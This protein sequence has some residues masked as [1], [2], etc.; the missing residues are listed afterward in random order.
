MRFQVPDEV[1]LLRKPLVTI[2]AEIRFLTAVYQHVLI[3]LALGRESFTALVTP[4]ILLAGVYF[5]VSVEVARTGKPA[6]KRNK[7]D[8]FKR[9]YISN[10]CQKMTSDILMTADGCQS[11]WSK[12]LF[13]LT[14]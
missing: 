1:R 8:S 11:Q 12:T 4:V 5:R 7:W 10:N 6:V 3:K 13:L 14:F 2:L 9:Y